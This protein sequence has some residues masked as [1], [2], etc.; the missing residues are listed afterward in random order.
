MTELEFIKFIH[1]LGFI[2]TWEIEPNSFHMKT[3]KGDGI[4][5]HSQLTIVLSNDD[6]WISSR[7]KSKKI[8]LYLEDITNNGMPS[9]KSFGTFDLESFGSVS[10]L[11]IQLFFS[12]IIGSF[13]TAPVKVLEYMRDEKIKN[14]LKK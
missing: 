14:I 5:N 1:Q 12:F 8:K 9:F 10:D 13:N 6:S 4:S 11:Q 7:P 2:K 3:D